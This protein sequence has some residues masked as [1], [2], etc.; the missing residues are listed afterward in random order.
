MIE[1]YVRK[2]RD[3]G[4]EGESTAWVE[5]MQ[6]LFM[7]EILKNLFKF[8]KMSVLGREFDLRMDIT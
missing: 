6:T 7:Y 1:K 5:I 2:L 8:L 4:V 3:I